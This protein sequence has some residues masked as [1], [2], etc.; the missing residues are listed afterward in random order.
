MP[1]HRGIA[2]RA[3]GLFHA[4]TGL[5]G[6]NCAPRRRAL[7]NF[8][9]LVASA[10]T[11]VTGRLKEAVDL[12][13]VLQNESSYV[14][15]RYTAAH[16]PLESV[17][18]WWATDDLEVNKL[19]FARL[20][21]CANDH[22]LAVG[23]A[24][25]LYT[26]KAAILKAYVQ[27]RLMSPI[28][29]DVALAIT[30]IG[31]SDDEQLASEVLADYDSSK[32]LLGTAAET[33]RSAMDRHR[34]TKHWFGAMQTASSEEC[35]WT[36]SSLFLKIVDARFD[37]LHRNDL[38]GT[39]VFNVWWWSVE[40]RVQRRFEKWSDKRKKTLLGSKAPKTI[41]LLQAEVLPAVPPEVAPAG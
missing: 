38:S 39:E 27:D 16:L 2:A 40:R 18:L 19:R 14:Q 33:C 5:A 32:G 8:W 37:A 22:D 10:L 9:L 21:R 29:A 30:V 4:R 7:R 24:A 11:H 12:L 36:A 26:G 23:A 34:W 1:A 25:A 41:Y 3:D 13:S 15:I 35:F 6:T 31:F 28:P 20:D 17:A